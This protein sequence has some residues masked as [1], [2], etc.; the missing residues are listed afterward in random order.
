MKKIFSVLMIIVL[1]LCLAGC[2]EVDENIPIRNNNHISIWT[3]PETQVQYIVYKQSGAYAGM[4][5]IT[6]RLNADGTLYIATE[7]GG[8]E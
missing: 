1:I 2:D 5:G 3:D 7:K 4:G 6:P 8:A